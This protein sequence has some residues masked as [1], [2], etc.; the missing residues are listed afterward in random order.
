MS[1]IGW[2]WQ[3]GNPAPPLQPFVAGVPAETVRISN[4]TTTPGETWCQVQFDLSD[5]LPA[6][7]RFYAVIPLVPLDLRRV[8]SWAT[9][10]HTVA[11][12]GLLPET[13]H[14]ALIVI[15]DGG[16]QIV[17]EELSFTTGPSA[18]STVSGRSTRP[19]MRAGSQH[20]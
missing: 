16:V 12:S 5:K 3:L 9:T 7:V 10:H 1:E 11:L 18:G 17:S 6:E 15:D 20:Q 8:P 19:R 4:I 2:W 13:Q 14:R